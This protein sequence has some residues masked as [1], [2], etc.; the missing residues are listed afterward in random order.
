METPDSE[1][2]SSLIY[3]KPLP[4]E[5]FFPLTLFSDSHLSVSF[6][7]LKGLTADNGS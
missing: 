7:I 6:I 2:F 4:K 5:T 1:H 3:F